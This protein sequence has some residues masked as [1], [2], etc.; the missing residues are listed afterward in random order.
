M[1]LSLRRAV[2]RAMLW[3]QFLRQFKGLTFHSWLNLLVSAIFEVFTSLVTRLHNPRLVLRGLD[4]FYSKS[5][6]ATFCVRGG[7]DD[8]YYLLM[9]REGPVQ[10]FIESVLRPGDVFVDVGANVGFYTILAAM[11]GARVIAVEAV[12]LTAAVLKAN[13][14]LNGF[15]NVVEV[16]DKCA[17]DGE[18]KIKVYVPKSGHFGLATVNSSRFNSA[19]VFE[20]ECIPLDKVLK[21]VERIR[22]VKL[23]VEGSELAVLNGLERALEKI[24]YVIAEVSDRE[25]IL[26]LLKHGFKVRPLGFTTYV[27]AV[28]V[29]KRSL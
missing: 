15:E 26:R 17:S 7:T 2:N 1:N 28:K 23:D 21:D 6:G 20:V 10:R 14:K 4:F 22:T 12:P 11:K 8:L 3:F 25:V 5:L 29:R 27:V 9:Y 24:D 13:I 19:L 16:I 18:H